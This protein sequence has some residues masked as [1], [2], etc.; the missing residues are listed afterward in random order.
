V[1]E[2]IGMQ[3][4]NN[5]LFRGLEVACYAITRADYIPDDAAYRLV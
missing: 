3:Y 2:K 5:M 4:K 1:I